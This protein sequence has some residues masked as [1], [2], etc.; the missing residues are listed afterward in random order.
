M[1][2]SSKGKKPTLSND[3]IKTTRGFGRR[4]FILGSFGGTAALAGCVSTGVTDSDLGVGSDPVGA[5]RGTRTGITDSDGGVYADPA[6]NGRGRRT[7]GITD[8]DLGAGSD[9]VGNG[10]GRRRITDADVGRYADPVGRGR[11]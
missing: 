3:D 5:G 7:T 9:P 1:T 6:G 11:G 10:R 2:D 8:S 4:A